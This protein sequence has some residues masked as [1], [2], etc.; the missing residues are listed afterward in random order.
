MGGV[1]MY[2]SLVLEH[3]PNILLD[4]GQCT[5]VS[6][7]ILL[8]LKRQR[9][10]SDYKSFGQTAIPNNPALFDHDLVRL[11]LDQSCNRKSELRSYVARPKDTPDTP[12]P[13]RSSYKKKIT[14][15]DNNFGGSAHR[16]IHF[17]PDSLQSAHLP[18]M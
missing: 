5:Y 6:P 17:V 18:L 9:S 7:S 1:Y 13:S 16:V 15:T 12:P 11:K 4:A 10:N 3:T 14:A 2:V 8:Y